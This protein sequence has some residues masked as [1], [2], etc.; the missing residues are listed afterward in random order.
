MK[1][2]RSNGGSTPVKEAHFM[3]REFRTDGS[4]LFLVEVRLV[5]AG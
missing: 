4:S 3:V 1:R 2:I 5:T